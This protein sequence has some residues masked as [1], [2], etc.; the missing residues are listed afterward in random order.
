LISFDRPGYGRSDRLPSRTG[1]FGVLGRS[2][3]GPQRARA[4]RFFRTG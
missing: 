4:L 3:G 2:G 1:R